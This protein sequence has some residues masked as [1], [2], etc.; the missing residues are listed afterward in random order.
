MCSQTYSQV[1]RTGS[2]LGTRDPYRLSR[3]IKGLFRWAETSKSAP[4]IEVYRLS[5]FDCTS[6]ITA[7]LALPA[8][9]AGV[10]EGPIFQVGRRGLSHQ[11]RKEPRRQ[12]AARCHDSERP[13]Q[14]AAGAEGATAADTAGSHPQGPLQVPHQN[15]RGSTMLGRV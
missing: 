14:R 1:S 15:A 8:E 12:H 3:L 6:G 5:R 11:D 9:R 10:P 4:I 13:R 2:S 7:T